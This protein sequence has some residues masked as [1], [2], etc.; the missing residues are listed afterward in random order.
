MVMGDE[1]S[2]RLQTL[3]GDDGL[4][5]L[6]EYRRVETAREL[7]TKVA[8]ELWSTDTPLTPQQSDELIRILAKNRSTQAALSGSGI[9]GYDWNAILGE[10]GGTLAEPQLAVLKGMQAREQFTQAIN[11]RSPTASSS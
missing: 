11:R 8:G 7:T 5:K 9:A 6:A 1:Y 10:T 4:Q 3:L 2:E